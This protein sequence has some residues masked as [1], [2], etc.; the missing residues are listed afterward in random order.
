MSKHGTALSVGQ[1]TEF[2]AAVIKALPRDI[3]PDIALSWANNG[4]ALA[5]VLRETLSSAEHV[6]AKPTLILHKKTN[7]GESSS[8]KTKDSFIGKFWINRISEI[9]VWLPKEQVAQA[10]GSVGIYQLQITEGTTFREMALAAVQAD[11][12]ITNE[13]VV[14]RLKGR[15]L[16]LTLPE[17]EMLV[18][19]QE[20]GEQTG[21]C[22]A[23]YANFAFVEKACG[24]VLVL[25]FGR[26]N[27]MWSTHVFRLENANLWHAAHRVLLRN[28]DI[29]S[30]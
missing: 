4:K 9:D 5:K 15:G 23:D 7:L 10:A 16:T 14:A 17:V 3:E 8:R 12:E 27:S 13:E 6:Q 20:A 30:L 11:S 29:R 24:S 19:R 28:S 21:L 2:A 25:Y 1:F 22:S 18:E 26:D